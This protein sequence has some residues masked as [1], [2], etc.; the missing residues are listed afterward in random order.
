MYPMQQVGIRSHIVTSRGCG[1][2]CTFCYEST[3]RKYRAH[4]PGRVI[5]EML[6]LQEKYGT[7]YFAFVDD[8]FTQNPRRLQQ[9]CE[10]LQRHFRPHQNL[11]WYCESRVDSLA[12]HPDLV[13]MMKDA[14]LVRIQIGTESGSQEVID[15]YKKEIKLEQIHAAVEQCARAQVL[16]VYTNFIIGGALETEHTFAET[17]KLAKTL[18]RVAPGRFECNTTYLSPY[19]MTDI[20]RNPNNYGI[21]ILD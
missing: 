4:S 7:T 1:F 9:I 3:N 20:E 6:D 13:P 8:V 12:R 21:E 17:L 18:L 11:F 5:D 2:R 14:G 19:P 16:S 10:L 15:A